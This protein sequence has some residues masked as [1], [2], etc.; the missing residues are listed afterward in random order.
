MKQ[1]FDQYKSLLIMLLVFIVLIGLILVASANFM[2]VKQDLTTRQDE[3]SKLQNKLTILEV[4]KNLT[5]SQIDFYN[6]LLS[7]LVPDKEDY[8]SILSALEQLSAQTGFVISQYSINLSQSA[9]GKLQLEVQGDGDANAFLKFLEVYQFGGG[10]LITNEQISYASDRIGQIKL[11]L[12][13][14][15]KKVDTTAGLVALTPS[16]IDLMR[17]IQSKTTFVFTGAGGASLP[18]GDYQTKPNPF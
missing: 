2:K 12:N 3:V 17:R 1:Y 7:Q 8:F 11:K 10:R 14:Y 4:N 15:S 18:I 13:F 6:K 9:P 16:Q 5:Q